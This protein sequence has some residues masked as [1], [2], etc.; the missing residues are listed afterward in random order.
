MGLDVSFGRYI[1]SHPF[2]VMALC[3]ILGD[4]GYLGFAFSAEGWV[5]LPKLGGALFTMAAHVVL[6]AYNDDEAQQ[7]SCE[8]GVLARVILNLRLITQ[9]ILRVLPKRLDH[10]VRTKPIGVPFLMLSMN[11]VGLSVDAVKGP[12]TLA[13]AVQLVL[14]ISVILG[15]GS[16]ALADFVI[17]QK[18]ADS[19]LKMA[20]TFLVAATFSNV[21]LAALTQN[22]F[23]IVSVLVFLTANYAGF[24]T[25]IDKKEP[26]SAGI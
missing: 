5:S 7:I 26:V 11:G 4:L 2:S 1:R 25:K 17:K 24:Y 12:A 19:L 3:N 6:L 10:L 16:F 23:L 22:G 13:F 20:P 8:N 15:C 21:V 9:N 18:H 14:G